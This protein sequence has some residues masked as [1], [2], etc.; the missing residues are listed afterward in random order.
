MSGCADSRYMLYTAREAVERGWVVARMN[1]RTCGGTEALSR[2]LYNAGQSDDVGEVLDAFAGAGESFPRP[3]F[4]AG[5]S[6]GANVVLRYAG[7]AGA[8]APVA[9][10]VAVNPPVDLAD[11][12][13][14]LELPRNRVYQGHYVRKLCEHLRRVRRVRGWP[15]HDPRPREIRTVRR[16]DDR[17]TALDAGFPSSAEYYAWASSGPYLAAVRRPT[18]VLSAANDPFVP[19]RL[20]EPHRGLRAI[21]FVHP[22]AGGHCGYWQRGRPR[23]WAARAVVTFLGDCVGD[24]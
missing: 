2:T 7:R 21:R 17:Y 19:L 14:D 11:C 23:N 6:L 8:A 3:W 18:L 22:E 10:F 24:G 16:F 4:V 1:L 13:R 15:D 5:F 12:L 20:F 9:G